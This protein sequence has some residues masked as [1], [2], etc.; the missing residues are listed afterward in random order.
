MDE[1]T[2]RRPA[3]GLSINGQP[4]SCHLGPLEHPS[5][6]EVSPGRTIPQ[7]ECHPS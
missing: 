2:D 3:V 1:E 7:T 4:D 6:P 5:Q